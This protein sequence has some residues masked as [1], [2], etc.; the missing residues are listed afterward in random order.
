MKGKKERTALA[1]TENAKVWASVLVK[2]R[3][4]GKPRR[5][6]ICFHGRSRSAVAGDSSARAGPGAA[7]ESMESD[8]IK[9]NAIVSKTDPRE[10]SGVHTLHE[11]T[12]VHNRKNFSRNLKTKDFTKSRVTE[13]HA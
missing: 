3:R 4:V 2:Y 7:A 8:F 12:L 9:G 1:A 5:W 10:R 13:Y 6:A 11:S